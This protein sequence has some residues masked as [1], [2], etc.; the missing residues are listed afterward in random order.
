M[1]THCVE[2]VSR[3]MAMTVNVVTGVQ[4]ASDRK[5]S[6]GRFRSQLKLPPESTPKVDWPIIHEVSLDL[7]MG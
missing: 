4:Y 1:L 6:A 3:P 7:I 2:S 5:D